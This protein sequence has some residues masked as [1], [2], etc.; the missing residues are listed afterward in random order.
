M[1]TAHDISVVICAYT[2]ERWNDLIEAI[3]S[4]KQQALL[5]SEI[6]VVV[7]HNPDLL[8]LAREHLRDVIV[9]E[10]TGARGLSG[11]RNS[12]IAVARGHIVVFLDDDAVATPNW[13]M[14]LN[15]AF[16]NPKVLG[17]GGP[18]IPLWSCR[19][20]TW[21]P[22]EFYWVVG[23]TYRG[24]PET[25]TIVRN[26][27]GANISFRREVFDTVGG[28]RSEIGRVGTQPLGCE[29]TELCIR[30]RQCWPQKG[31]LYQPEASVFHHVP[32]NRTSWRYFFSRCYSE[33]LSKAFVSQYVGV[34][35]G[36]ASERV[37]TFRILPQ[38]VVR[39]LINALFHHDLSGFAR[40]GAIITGLAATTA[41]YL[42]G[43]VFL[44]VSRNK[45]DTVTNVVIRRN[46]EASQSLTA[47][48]GS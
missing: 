35:E 22:E 10:N 8:K 11:A 44:R 23:C 14:F 25:P 1:Q 48:T 43:S 24:M 36:L 16:S 30:A 34:K 31:F 27:I 26:P 21:L 40:A 18:V 32:G 41:G 13:L 45:R 29:E 19:K 4:V 38:G 33:G 28:F 20:P 42:A 7:D 5:P 6:I 12:G 2:E 39:C 46:V 9:V 15:E 3:A 37:Y 17:A 47:R